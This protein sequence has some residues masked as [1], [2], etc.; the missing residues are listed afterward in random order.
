MYGSG[1]DLDGQRRVALQDSILRALA[2][3]SFDVRVPSELASLS[4]HNLRTSGIP[5]ETFPL[6]T[7]LTTLGT[8]ALVAA[9]MI[10]SE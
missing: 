3:T 2:A 6:K 9:R 1:V 5:L 4:L 8:V 7:I 10:I